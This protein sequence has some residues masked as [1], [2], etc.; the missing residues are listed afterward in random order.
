MTQPSESQSGFLHN[1]KRLFEPAPPATVAP[2]PGADEWPPPVQELKHLEVA[3][4]Q[5]RQRTTDTC[6]PR[7]PPRQH[8]EAQQGVPAD[9]QQALE[10]VHKQ[11][12]D[13]ILALHAQLQ[14]HLTLEEIQHA[15]AVMRELDGSCWG[16]QGETW[17]CG[18]EPR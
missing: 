2:A 10:A 4:Q 12:G 16:R 3:L 13:A 11:A 6:P 14:T 1:F 17:S 8:N 7:Q 5:L 15:Q 9:E 18:Q